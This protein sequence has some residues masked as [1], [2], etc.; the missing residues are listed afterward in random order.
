MQKAEGPSLALPDAKGIGTN[1]RVTS[2]T[3]K[4]IKNKKKEAEPHI[5]F[6]FHV[7]LAKNTSKFDKIK[8]G[9]IPDYWYNSP[10]KRPLTDDSGPFYV[11]DRRSEPP[12]QN[13]NL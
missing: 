8:I 13:P 3:G 5:D 12:A 9:K 7:W 2:T 11:V 6:R 4:S 1:K 10:K